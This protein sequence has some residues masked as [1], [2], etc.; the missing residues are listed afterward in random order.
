MTRPTCIAC[1]RKHLMQSRA[2]LMEVRK[3]Y[4][5]YWEYAIGHMAEAEDEIA[6]QYPA[7]AESIRSER[8]KVEATKGAHMPEWEPLVLKLRGVLG[9]L[10]ES[11]R[12]LSG[13]IEAWM[14]EFERS[15]NDLS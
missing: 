9:D 6:D 11:E 5:T 2:I 14:K 3:G 13:E 7:V 4:P 1:S 8:I 12:N 15:R 10:E